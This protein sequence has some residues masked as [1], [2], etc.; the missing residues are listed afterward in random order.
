MISTKEHTCF[1]S[2]E[3]V[4]YITV[5]QNS[6]NSSFK[7]M[8]WKFCHL[9]EEESLLRSYLI[10]DFLTSPIKQLISSS[11]F[12]ECWK[13][14]LQ[15]MTVHS[16]LKRKNGLTSDAGPCYTVRYRKERTLGTSYFKQMFHFLS[17]F[18]SLENLYFNM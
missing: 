4:A 5:V 16:G 2:V 3:C 9:I 10:T 14:K 12:T 18:F 8:F 7:N 6:K 1:Y 13:I 11:F 15:C 17:C